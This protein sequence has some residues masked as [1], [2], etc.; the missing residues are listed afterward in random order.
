MRI[1]LQEEIIK[2]NE[3]DEKLRL[4]NAVQFVISKNKC[5]NEKIKLIMYD[6]LCEWAEVVLAKRGYNIIDCNRM[7]HVIRDYGNIESYSIDINSIKDENATIL[8]HIQGLYE[9][10]I[11]VLENE[12]RE[13]EKSIFFKMFK[14][15]NK[16]IEIFKKPFREIIIH[17]FNIN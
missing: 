1:S 2:F 14:L 3:R 6:K 17:N 5:S 7:N 16:I 10:M 4:R 13:Y 12:N 15:K 11:E 9:K 8:L